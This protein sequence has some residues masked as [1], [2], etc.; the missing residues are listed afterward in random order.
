MVGGR[1]LVELFEVE[2]LGKRIVGRREAIR[3]EGFK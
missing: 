1:A 2:S 3:K